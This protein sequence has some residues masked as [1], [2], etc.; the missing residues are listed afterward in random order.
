[1]NRIAYNKI[2]LRWNTFLEEKWFYKQI[3]HKR[4]EYDMT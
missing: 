2:P 4:R 1:L 3:K